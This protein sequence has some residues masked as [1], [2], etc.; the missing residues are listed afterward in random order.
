MA[1]VRERRLNLRPSN[2]ASPE[3][4]SRPP[5]QRAPRTPRTASSFPLASSPLQRRRGDYKL[6]DFDKLGVLARQAAARVYKGPPR[7]RSNAVHPPSRSCS[8]STLRPRDQPTRPSHSLARRSVPSPP[9]SA[10]SGDARSPAASSWTLGSLIARIGASRA[11]PS[12]RS[13]PT[14]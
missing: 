7:R 8:P 13:P 10:A 12:P 9:Y 11:P 2:S 6:S 5:P 1:A 4:P 14:T 3:S